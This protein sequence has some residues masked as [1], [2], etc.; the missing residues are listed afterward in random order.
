MR[1]FTLVEV[2]WGILISF[3]IIAIV[4]SCTS[5]TSSPS[6]QPPPNPW[7]VVSDDGYPFERIRVPG[8]WVYRQLGFQCVALTFVPDPALS[9]EEDER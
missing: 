3:M 8:G 4:G 9:I 1:G 2:T 6:I 7:E 5:V